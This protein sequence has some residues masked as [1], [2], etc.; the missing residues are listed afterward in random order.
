MNPR[1][2]GISGPFHGNIL[3]LSA[4]EASI[5][6][7]PSNHLW[8]T[9]PALSRRHCLVIRNGDQV[10]IRDLESRNGT[11]VNGMPIR[12]HSLHH[13][14]QISIGDS[15]LV[16]LVEED[17]DHHLNRSTVEL[18]DTAD[19]AAGSHLTLRQEDA[20]YLQPDKLAAQLPPTDRVTRHLNALLKIATGIGGIRDLESLQW[21]LLGFIFEIVPADRGAILMAGDPDDFSSAIAWDRILGPGHPVRV[22]RTIAKRVLRDRTGMVVSD[23]STDKEL[24]VVPTLADLRVRSLLCVPLLV[25]TKALGAIYLDSRSPSEKFD[26]NHLQVMTAV[27]GI[28]SLALDN[29]QHW[30]RLRQENQD[31]RAEINLDHNMVGNSPRIREVFDFIRRVAPTDSTVLIHGESGT[32]KELVARAVHR[33][34]GRAEGPFVAINCAAIAESLLESELFGHERGAFTGAVAQKKGKVEVAQGGTLFLDE[35]SELAAGLQAKLLR[36]LQEREFERLGGTRPIALDIRLI[37]AT[38]RNLLEAIQAGTFRKDLYYR[39]NVVAVNM[40]ALR[41]RREDIGLLAEHFIAKASRKNRTR[42]KPLSPEAHACLMNYDWPGNVRELENA[43]ERALVLGSSDAIAPDDLPESL[44][45]A[46]SPAAT[47]NTKYHGALKDTKKQLVLQALQQG[48]G[49]Y[50]EAA[51]ILGMHPNSLLRLIRNLGLKA[52]AKGIEQA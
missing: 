27:A 3:T 43:I 22:S 14:D 45:E 33:N 36:V 37:A 34:S 46:S 23:V 35:I 5:G 30:E 40:P 31:L 38:N 26:E 18:A 48:N 13:G 28:A 20:L 6:R 12:E 41:E 29:V 21:Q 42:T 44:L 11:A 47:S 51:K 24:R 1:F 4:G 8:T 50:I 25:S 32:G 10:T 49:N 39:L 52:A 9:D 16:F 19:T 15:V 17:E 2:L 7:E